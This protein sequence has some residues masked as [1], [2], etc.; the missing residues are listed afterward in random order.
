MT[1]DP[2]CTNVASPVASPRL[3]V[4]LLALGLFLRTAAL[5]LPGTGD[6]MVFKI[7]A[8]AAAT[9]PVSE[10][11]G[12]G[13]SPPERRLHE[14]DGRRATV[15]YPPAA[16]YELALVGLAYGAAFPG[17]PNTPALTAAVKL[18]PVLTEA[19]IA[20]LLFRTVASIVPRGREAARYAALA[21]W[22]NPAAILNASVLGYLDPLFAFPALASLIAA[23]AGTP[24][25]AGALLGC[26]VLTKAQAVLVAPAVVLAL[27]SFAGPGQL[28][29]TAG[30]IAKA[31]A[32]A[33]LA[34][35]GLLAPVAVAGGWPNLLQAMASLGRHD[36]L[37]G[38]AANLWWIVTYVMRA[39]YAVPDM[40]L[41]GAL[42]SPV[43][44]PL[45][46]T[47]I[48]G[49]GYPSPRPAATL[50]ALAAAAWGIWLARR[51]RDLPRL[52]LLGAWVCYAYFMLAVQV[53]ENHFFMVLPL[54]A[55]TAAARPEWRAQF[56]VLSGIF[57][58]NLNLFYGFGAQVGFAVPRRIT[59]LDATVW[60][61]VANVITFGWFARR[62]AVTL[63]EG[64]IRPTAGPS[65]SPRPRE[66][67]SP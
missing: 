66:S 53:H 18:L 27:W 47:T 50:A 6:V 2:G 54:L 25:V 41:A 46:I 12:V 61:A 16:L 59:G 45:A 35:V 31:A 11:Y 5:P 29:S 37:S 49:L 26:A 23:S 60:L 33:G 56:W 44:R 20:L 67:W 52:A 58:L 36:M 14:Y 9:G 15:D 65:D 32:G 8:H 22:L 19:L 24:F 55:L 3:F 40:G 62:L 10:M 28:R 30:L 39:V 21:Y 64:S 51:V 48:V 57:A 1:A 42:L 63:R 34:T 38:Q 7:W 43:R 4:M 17:F 13:G